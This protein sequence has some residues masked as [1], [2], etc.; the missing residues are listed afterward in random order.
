M[1]DEIASNKIPKSDLSIQSDK[2][3]DFIDD[4]LQP[5]LFGG[6]AGYMI[7]AGYKLPT[8]VGVLVGSVL[9]VFVKQKFSW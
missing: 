5:A 9:G 2:K 6:A 8:E 3:D 7:S 1:S 4:Y